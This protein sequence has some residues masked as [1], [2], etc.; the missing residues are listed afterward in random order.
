MQFRSATT[1]C[2]GSYALDT[3]CLLSPLSS[4]SPGQ[5][6]FLSFLDY[7]FSPNTQLNQFFICLQW[8][9]NILMQLSACN[10]YNGHGWTA[11]CNSTEDCIFV[12]FT[13][14]QSN[15]AWK[16]CAKLKEWNEIDLN[17]E[18]WLFFFQQYSDFVSNCSSV[19]PGSRQPNICSIHCY[20]AL[21]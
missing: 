10:I 8:T 19:F 13:V 9:M 3:S 12:W 1:V 6:A 14:Y 17:S 5:T 16:F 2:H 4:A 7:T 15:S 11:W 20:I 21:V 18:G